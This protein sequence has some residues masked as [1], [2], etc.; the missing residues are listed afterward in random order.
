MSK[1]IN[2]TLTKHQRVKNHLIKKGSITS[3][4]AIQLFSATRLSAIIHTLRKRGLDIVTKDIRIKDK[5]GNTSTYAKY[6][7]FS[8]EV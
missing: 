4:D 6:K 7:Y 3:W 2:K 5:Y 1:T 8:N